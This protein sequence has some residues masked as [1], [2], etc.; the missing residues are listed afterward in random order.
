[1]TS[2]ILPFTGMDIFSN[3]AMAQKNGYDKYVDYDSDLNY[4]TGKIYSDYPDEVN[5][6]E[7]QKGPLEG[8]FVS[9]VEFCK[10]API[11]DGEGN[12]M[13]TKDRTGIIDSTDSTEISAIKLYTVIG[14]T[15]SIQ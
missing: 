4:N 15:T 7:C 2:T 14:N 8:F 9:S 5:K 11:I 12:V 3:T 6:Y 13:D 1:M 10:R